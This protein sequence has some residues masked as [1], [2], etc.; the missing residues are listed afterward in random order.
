MTTDNFVDR[1]IGPRESDAVEMC[2]IIGVDTAEQLIEQ[3]VPAV[4]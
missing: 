1:H 2:K 3:T 4:R